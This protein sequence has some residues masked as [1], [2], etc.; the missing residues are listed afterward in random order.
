MI[1]YIFNLVRAVEHV[2]KF[3]L[4]TKMKNEGP[5]WLNE[6]VSW[7]TSQLIQAYHQYSVGSHPAV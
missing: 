5:G 3:R 7:I 6:L 4:K 1:M 2:F